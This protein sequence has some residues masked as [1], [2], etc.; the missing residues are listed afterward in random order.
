MTI[1]GGVGAVAV[2]PGGAR[3]QAREILSDRRYRSEPVPRPLRGLL[4]WVGDR[5]RSLAELVADMLRSIP[6][7][8]WVGL[9]VVA[10]VIGALLF[11]RLTSRP[12]GRPQRRGSKERADAAESEDP[13]VLEA[14]AADAERRGDMSMA[15]RLRFRAGLLRLDERGAIEF[16]PSLT[17][18]EVRRLLG[19]ETFEDLASVF[20]EVAYGGRDAAA[21]EPEKAREAWKSL[22]SQER[23]T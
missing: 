5:L 23:K 15:L 21:D 17:T 14:A 9:A 1:I 16:R 18:G 11:A 6:G 22:L 3:E 7:P 10:V 4:E 8:T 20:E 12:G 13:A 19:S 2:D